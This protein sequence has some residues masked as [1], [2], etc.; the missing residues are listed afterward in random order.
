MIR[1]DSLIKEVRKYEGELADYNLALD[2]H[3]TDTKTEDIL[4]LYQHIRMQN[5]KQKS[6]LDDLFIERK[7]FENEIADYDTQINEIN[8]ANEERLNELDPEQRNEYE[9]LKFE[10]LNLQREIGNHRNE[11]DDVNNKLAN[12]DAKLKGD[13]LRQRAQHLREEKQSLLKKREELELQTNE[14]N[15]PFPEARER[16]L[17]RI[18]QDNAEILQAEKKVNEV[19]KMIETYQRNIREIEADLDERKSDQADA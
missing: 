7:E 8:Q 2:K 5:E 15:L 17:N 3:R 11:L 18:K 6:Q 10:N 14:S 4:A 9:K 13:T 1:Y 12:A 16:L 19:K